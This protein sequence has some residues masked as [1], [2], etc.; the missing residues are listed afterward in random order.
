MKTNKQYNDEFNQS[1]GLAYDA[2]YVPTDVE[3]KQDFRL[4]AIHTPANGDQPAPLNSEGN[5][6]FRYG[7]T[8]VPLEKP[9]HDRTAFVMMMNPGN[10]GKDPNEL[11]VKGDTA[12]KRV[13]SQLKNEYKRIFIVNT[14]PFYEA[15]S[16]Q[17]D[18]TILNIES[19][20][21]ISPATWEQQNCETIAAYIDF[22]AS[23]GEAQYDVLL[24]TGELTKHNRATF[25]KLMDLFPEDIRQRHLFIGGDLL[26]T[27]NAP[28]LSNSR[29]RFT[30]TPSEW[31]HVALVS[32]KVAKD[33]IYHLKVVDGGVEF[34]DQSTLDQLSPDP[35]EV[36]PSWI[37]KSSDEELSDRGFTTEE[38]AT[39]RST[40]MAEQEALADKLL[41]AFMARQIRERD[42]RLEQQERQA[43]QQK[44]EEEDRIKGIQ[45]KVESRLDEYVVAIRDAASETLLKAVQTEN[46]MW[47]DSYTGSIK[48]DWYSAIPL[49]N[50]IEFEVILPHPEP[51]H[52]EYVMASGWLHDADT[53]DS[54]SYYGSWLVKRLTDLYGFNHHT[55]HYRTFYGDDRF[56]MWFSYDNSAHR[57]LNYN[58]G[59]EYL[60]NEGDGA[61]SLVCSFDVACLLDTKMF[62]NVVAQIDRPIK[63]FKGFKEGIV[64]S[65]YTIITHD[66][67]NS[68]YYEPQLAYGDKG[69]AV[70]DTL[71]FNKWKNGELHP[72]A[73]EEFEQERAEEA[74]KSQPAKPM[75]KIKTGQFNPAS[76]MKMDDE[77]P[78]EDLSSDYT[79]KVT[80][81]QMLINKLGKLLAQDAA[82]YEL[83]DEDT[84]YNYEVLN[85]RGQEEFTHLRIIQLPKKF[86]VS[87]LTTE[88]QQE[89]E[90]WD[91]LLA[92]DIYWQHSLEKMY[93]ERFSASQADQVLEAA[94]KVLPDVRQALLAGKLAEM[95]Q[96]SL[97]HKKPHGFLGK[98]AD[99]F[100][101]G[102]L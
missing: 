70:M 65:G 30:Y 24:G 21:Q 5:Y 18:N 15:D 90:D 22:L 75:K 38:I 48:S 102:D 16:K 50:P 49:I 63:Q 93:H 99:K 28:Y 66:N 47:L 67:E 23:E 88:L 73:Q 17:I 10:A 100:L 96:E 46:E 12:V 82:L 25:R 58:Y 74:E 69:V 77:Q 55:D 36:K 2:T 80:P 59:R 57:T 3:K 39:L 92:Y 101:N 1:V 9:L 7:M 8:L 33:D 89:V 31:H 44:A 52:N 35:K 4:F 6:L 45:D 72:K 11:S 40:P 79:F 87:Q 61:I 34:S 95:K 32:G 68:K 81:Y 51:Y 76:N 56:E 85:F 19:Q 20:Y 26:G 98:L 86:K 97:T 13:Y 42:E 91:S 78:E 84:Y 54:P 27:A 64:A 29:N 71:V 37:S 83:A 94:E 41:K 53:G 62:E 14:M 60:P 43:A